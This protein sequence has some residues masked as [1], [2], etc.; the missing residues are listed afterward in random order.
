MIALKILTSERILYQ[1]QSAKA[2]NTTQRNHIEARRQI[3]Y[4]APLGECAGGSPDTFTFIEV[5][6]FSG[7]AE[8]GPSA[9]FDFN[10]HQSA[11]VQRHQVDLSTGSAV[12][13]SQYQVATS[14]QMTRGNL[15]AAAA[16]GDPLAPW[17]LIIPA[18]EYRTN[19]YVW[20]PNDSSYPVRHSSTTNPAALILTSNASAWGLKRYRSRLHVSDAFLTRS[21]P[22]A[23]IIARWM[24]KGLP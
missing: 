1:L 3:R 19:V 10:E 23:K 2:A 13:S 22:D 24:K 7:C 21:P 16:C 20:C 6:G 14:L 4:S 12:V 15:L 5:H 18:V 11:M 9:E 8:P 17:H